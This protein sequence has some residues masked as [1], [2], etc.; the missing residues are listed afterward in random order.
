MATAPIVEFRQNS[1]PFAVLSSL[2]YAQSAI[3]GNLLP[4]LGGEVSFVIPFRVYNNFTRTPGTATMH[5]VRMTVFDDANPASHTFAKS[6]ASQSWVRIYETGFGEN[7]T[8]PGIYTAYIGE[9]TAIGRS[10]LDSYTPEY[11][12]DGIPTTQNTPTPR[13]R[14]GT[15]TNGVGFIEFAS[16]MEVPDVVGFA[17]YTLAVSIV[18]DWAP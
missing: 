5:N 18:Y 4:I 10:G 13:I 7:S 16:Y 3:G 12:S 9:D 14:A 6:P 15:D 8:A 2:A 1:S 11:G 17:S